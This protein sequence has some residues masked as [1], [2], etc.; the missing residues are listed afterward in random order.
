MPE[1]RPHPPARL[2]AA[3][4][5]WTLPEGWTPDNLGHCRSCMAAVLW[6]YTAAGRKAPANPDGSS[7]FATCPD[8]PA[9]RRKDVRGAVARA[10][11]EPTPAA[12][13]SRLA[14]PAG[15]GLG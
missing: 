5:G 3:P 14:R 7:H 6:C 15:E 9:W 13:L 12:R 2:E 4:A 1:P 8:G 11:V 10:H